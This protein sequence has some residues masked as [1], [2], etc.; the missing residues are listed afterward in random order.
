MVVDVRPGRSPRLSTRLGWKPFALGVLLAGCL[1]VVLVFALRPAP[2]AETPIRAVDLYVSAR[3]QGD[4]GAMANILNGNAA[5]D[6]SKLSEVDGRPVDVTA[7]NITRSDISDVLYNVTVT[8]TD[9]NHLASTDKLMVF[10]RQ[11]DPGAS[12][13]WSVSV[14]P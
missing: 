3:E 7:V 13:D 10:P 6:A 4:R 5:L 1:V 8:W 9:A 2:P 11:G 14:A 12:L